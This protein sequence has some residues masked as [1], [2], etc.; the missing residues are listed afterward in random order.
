MPG[1]S[2]TAGDG[3][4]GA[5]FETLLIRRVRRPFIPFLHTSSPGFTLLAFCF[6]LSALDWLIEPETR[7]HR[8]HSGHLSQFALAILSSSSSLLF[9]NLSKFPRFVCIRLAGRPSGPKC[10]SLCIKCRLL[11]Q[12]LSASQARL[13]HPQGFVYTNVF[14]LT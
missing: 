3:A 5:D 11:V 9:I 13:V 6:L 8:T 2:H 1:I 10:F 12:G 4:S 14:R 7:R